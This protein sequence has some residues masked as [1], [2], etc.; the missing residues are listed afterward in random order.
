[1]RAATG[2]HTHAR[3]PCLQA[4]LQV[5]RG[6]ALMGGPAA[7]GLPPHE[8][9]SWVALHLDAAAAFLGPN[10]SKGGACSGAEGGPGVEAELQAGSAYQ[11]GLAA[12]AGDGHEPEPTAGMFRAEE[13]AQLLYVLARMGLRPPQRWLG[14][15]LEVLQG[16][17]IQELARCVCMC[18][19]RVARACVCA[20]GA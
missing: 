2:L 7:A 18:V 9:S 3:A 12:P 10:S 11:P 8:C 14:R 20:C 13:L 16:S 17:L 1:M 19:V 6:V 4:L 15:A 5:V